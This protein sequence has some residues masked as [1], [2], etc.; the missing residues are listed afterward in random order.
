MYWYYM[1][2]GITIQG[3][4]FRPRTNSSAYNQTYF[5]YCD[6]LKIIDCTWTGEAGGAYR[7][8]G[9]YIG[10]SYDVEV[11]NCKMYDFGGRTTGYSYYYLYGFQIYGGGTRD[12][13]F[14]G[15]EITNMAPSTWSADGDVYGFYI[16]DAGGGSEIRNNLVHHWDLNNT[17]TSSSDYNIFYGAYFNYPRN[18]AIFANNTF[19]QLENNSG[20]ASY[21]GSSCYGIQ[22]YGTSSS[23][24]GCDFYNNI[25]T[26][27]YSWNPGQAYGRYC[28]AGGNYSLTYNDCWD[29]EYNFGYYGQTATEFSLDPL[30]ENATTEPYDYTLQDTSPC[31]TGGAGGTE[32]GAYG[33]LPA[34]E[35]VG[36]LTPE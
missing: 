26:S 11:R 36:L 9:C 32:M 14:A 12:I 21:V 2:G 28:Y 5:Y 25:S 19:D 8:Y 7:T 16:A 20:G 30:Y 35:T 13:I 29:N 22:M 1:N 15:N 33:E 6:D 31:L 10:Y 18:G 4:E 23:S 34:G 27:H 24:Y 17:S 3:F